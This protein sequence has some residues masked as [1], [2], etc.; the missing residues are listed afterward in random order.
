MDTRPIGIFDSGV[1][2]LTV[3][4][5]LR[6]KLPNE[7]YI[8]IGD[9]KRFPYGSKSKETIIQISK[10]IVDTLISKKVK[11]IVIACGTAT[12]QA[13]EELKQ[14]YNIPIIGIIEPTVENQMNEK[15]KKVGV[16]ATRGTIRSKVWETTICKKNPS[17]AIL[18]KET[19]LLAPMAEEG[20]IDNEV[21]K[22]A[23]KEYMK[24]WKEE[25]LDAL[26]LGC[27]HYPLFEKLLRKE[28]GDTIKIINTG[29]EIAKSL[30]QYLK[31]N[32]LKNEGIGTEEIYLTDTESNFLNVAKQL[33]HKEIKIQKIDL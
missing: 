31:E 16:I 8:Y 15:V 28:L 3:L 13:L 5:E 14:I 22:S 6:K 2:G 10:R 1:G 18:S 19:P 25:N 21:A 4:T 32:D 23:I 11:L 12:S 33:F 24:D 29:K 30:E 20:W 9:T 26:I 27:T 17:I 7:N